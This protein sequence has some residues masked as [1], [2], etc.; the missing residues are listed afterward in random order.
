VKRRVLTI[1]DVAVIVNALMMVKTFKRE[2]KAQKLKWT[3]A[4]VVLIKHAECF[5]RPQRV[6]LKT[7]VL[8][9]QEIAVIS[10]ASFLHK[11]HSKQANAHQ[12]NAKCFVQ[13]G[14]KKDDKGCD[15]CE[16]AEGNSTSSFGP[17]ML[18]RITEVSDHPAAKVFALVGFFSVFHMMFKCAKKSSEYDVL[19][20]HKSYS[21]VTEE[22]I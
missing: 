13:T 16:C 7:I 15:T 11:T 21:S 10:I 6:N 8:C 9:D 5:A 2:V 3:I 22:E 12:N 4:K 18:Q 14:S 17:K 1:G 20:E 19:G